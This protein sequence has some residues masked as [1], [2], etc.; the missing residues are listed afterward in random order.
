MTYA[1]KELSPET[2]P[3]FERLFAPGTGWAFC[4]CMLY[5]RASH[6]DRAQFPTREAARIQIRR[7][8][9]RS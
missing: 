9:A 4:A 6:L 5:Q 2:W 1:T 3:D 8:S 7:R